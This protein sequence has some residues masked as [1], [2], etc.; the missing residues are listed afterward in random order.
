MLPILSI[1]SSPY[2]LTWADEELSRLLVKFRTWLDAARLLFLLICHIGM[3]ASFAIW[4]SSSSCA[5]DSEP[6]CYCS[7]VFVL[8]DIQAPDSLGVCHLLN[9][10]IIIASWVA[11]LLRE[12]NCS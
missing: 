4:N 2:L 7:D 5:D 10:Y 6:S 12:F 3:A 11:P 9:V 1:P 8:T